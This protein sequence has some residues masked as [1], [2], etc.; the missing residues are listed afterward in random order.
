M[1]SK[2][3]PFW[4]ACCARDGCHILQRERTGQRRSAFKST[5]VSL[6]TLCYGHYNQSPLSFSLL[7]LAVQ[8]VRTHTHTLTQIIWNSH[9]S[10]IISMAGGQIYG[11]PVGPQ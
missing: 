4:P 3:G 2:T 7:C 1:I 5:P 10:A 9:F 6:L 11:Q 8:H